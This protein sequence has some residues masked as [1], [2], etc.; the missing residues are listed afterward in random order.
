MLCSS[1]NEFALTGVFSSFAEVDQTSNVI[2]DVL[3]VQLEGLDGCSLRRV[4]ASSVQQRGLRI[5]IASS[6]RSLAVVSCA[7]SV[8]IQHWLALPASYG[9]MVCTLRLLSSTLTPAHSAGLSKREFTII[10]LMSKGLTYK[11]IEQCLG[12]K[13]SALRRAQHKAFGKLRVK[14]RTEAVLAASGSLF[15]GYAPLPR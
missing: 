10:S 4:K 2:A 3:I 12:L 1:C 8:G 6:I 14:S 9:Q 13:H 5:V 11:E 7:A 15:N